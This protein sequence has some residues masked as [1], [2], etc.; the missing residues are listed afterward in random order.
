MSRTLTTDTSPFRLRRDPQSDPVPT[1][2]S[3]SSLNT[4]SVSPFS[5]TSGPSSQGSPRSSPPIFTIVFSIVIGLAVILAL[6]AF[7][8]LMT[9]R[10]RRCTTVNTDSLL[11]SELQGAGDDSARRT[12]LARVHV[13]GPAALLDG[14]RDALQGSCTVQTPP[15]H[16]PATTHSV[17][18]SSHPDAAISRYWAPSGLGHPEAQIS[19]VSLAGPIQISLDGHPRARSAPQHEAIYTHPIARP[20]SPSVVSAGSGRTEGHG[21]AQGGSVQ[22][23]AAVGVQGVGSQRS[24]ASTVEGF[25][26]LMEVLGP[27]GIWLGQGGEELPPPYEASTP[28]GGGLD[29]EPRA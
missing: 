13:S 7:V 4:S 24:S 8:F 29:D 3:A 19:K 1:T 15:A 26:H 28:G 21:G 27:P 5:T 6:V 18:A 23:R 12:Y 14:R 20:Y 25:T 17:Y 22:N 9:R 2:P 11:A 10:G 16:L